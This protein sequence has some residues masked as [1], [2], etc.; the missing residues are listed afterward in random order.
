[1]LRPI[2]TDTQSDLIVVG[3]GI[4]GLA[5]ALVG[6][7]QGLRVQVV[8]REPMCTGASIR[9][10]GFVTVTGQGSG[11]SWQRARRTR[12]IWAQ[13]APQAGIAVE[14]SGLYVQAQRPEAEAVLREL[15]LT[16]QGAQCEWLSH[17]QLQQRAPHLA[18]AHV[19]GALYSPH[20]LRIEA[21]FAIE[22]LRL[23]LASRGVRFH[24]GQAAQQVSA[25]EVQLEARRL[26]AARI[27]V[28]PGADI[29]SLFAPVFAQH[30][31]Q[32]CQLQM[33]RIRPPD[34]YRLGAAL[35]SDLS[36]V[37][38]RG[39]RELPG[40]KRM[41]D[42]LRVE[43]PHTVQHGVHLIVVQ[44]A[45]GSLIVGDSHQYGDCL[46]PFAAQ[47]VEERILAEMQ[48]MLCLGHYRVEQRWSGVY[49]SGPQDAFM[50]TV[51]PGVQLLSVTSGSGMSTAFALA[52]E[53]L[54]GERIA[55]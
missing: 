3:A 50:Q 24:M 40:A 19:R 31:T 45:D 54:G 48:R 55:L 22:K 46:A 1:M 29:R 26:Q 15:L 8:E 32:L 14:H 13:V 6:V 27:V 4:V 20:E 2:D 33:L 41:E 44:S 21:R 43:V 9:N 42:R 28:C 34:N 23:W 18:P 53:C 5:C 11:E 10:F 35:M 38:Y 7:E 49:P 25:G 51:L 37:R 12:D 52:E 47:E 39:F 30:Q 36:L 17:A 16:A